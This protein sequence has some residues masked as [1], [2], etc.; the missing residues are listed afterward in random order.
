[1]FRY[2]FKSKTVAQQN[3]GMF[4]RQQKEKKGTTAIFKCDV[5]EATFKV[6][7]Y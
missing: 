1:M 3:Q 7:P 2:H 4:H 5:C 6:F